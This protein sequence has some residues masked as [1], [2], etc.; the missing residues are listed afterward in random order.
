MSEINFKSEISGN[1]F[2]KLTKSVGFFFNGLKVFKAYLQF[3]PGFC[4]FEV[5][6]H[7]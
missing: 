2:P 4:E 6:P 1:H 5:F 3:N 7:Q